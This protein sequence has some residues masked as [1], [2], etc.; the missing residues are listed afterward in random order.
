[1][2]NYIRPRSPD[3]Q[4]FTLALAHRQDDLL[5]R[6]AGLLRDSVRKVKKDRPFDILAFVV[7]PDHLHEIC[8][9][10]TGDCDFSNR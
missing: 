9:L 7:L 3:R 6:Q 10:P 5:A 8:Q 4:F 2:P 1:M